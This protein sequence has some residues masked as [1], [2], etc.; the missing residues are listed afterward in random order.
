MSSLHLDPCPSGGR[1][2]KAIIRRASLCVASLVLGLFAAHARAQTTPAVQGTS[3][4]DPAVPVVITT[5]PAGS[6]FF[7]LNQD[8]S[9]LQHSTVDTSQNQSCPGPSI[10][11]TT[12]PAQRTIVADLYNAYVSGADAPGVSMAI[13]GITPEVSCH[14]TNPFDYTGGVSAQSLAA[15]DT[16]HGS[17]FL[18][19]AYGGTGI[20]TLMVLNNLNNATVSSG[21]TFT[22]ALQIALDQNGQ[23]TSLVPDV[24]SDFGLT[25]ITELKTGTSP[26]NLW[27]YD[28]QS[29]NV[30]KILGP[31][32]VSLPAVTSFIIPPQTGGGGL[33]VLVN[34][35][36]LTA[37]NIG[38]PPQETAP[39]TIIDLGQLRLLFATN[40][41]H[42][43]ITLPFVEQIQATTPFYAMLGAAYN[44]I[45]HRIYAVVGGGTS[46]TNVVE[47]IL[48]YD[49]LNPSAP[50]EK[51]VADV[52]NVPFSLGSYPQLALSAASG[53]MQILTSNPAAVYSVGIDGTGNTAVEVS[54]TTFPDSNF[55]PTYIAANALQGE[56]YIASASGQV[57]VL[58]RPASLQG[59]LTITLTGPD[60]SY[61]SQEYDLTPLA[62]W[63]LYDASLGTAKLT[64]TVT[65]DGGA[66]VTVATGH[67]SDIGYPGSSFYTYTFPAPGRYTFV[68]T[69]EASAL[70]PAVTSP[71][72]YVYVGNTGVYPTAV[73]LTAPSTAPSTNGEATF[74]ATV[75]LTG[76]TYAPTGQVYI[77]DQTG[78]EVANISLPAGVISNPLTL[79]VTIG[80]G[81]S[82]L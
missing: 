69:A 72:L 4:A 56:T 3:I 41:A 31:G 51:V 49:T 52:S 65:P 73:S 59:G 66:P 42:N 38:A 34:Q 43:T 19:S 25:A 62:L 20:D 67:I 32:G 27:V 79:P 68:A 48:S 10:Y 70:Y 24:R 22:G 12:D 8:Y 15:N 18:V 75:N 21:N 60:L 16:Q 2:M 14:M 77:Q 81:V 7:V 50:A 46:L 71:P 44:P 55:Q 45:D 26:G 6:G 35:H 5:A 30:F 17:Y 36:G 47:S 74:N 58:T 78:A 11:S 1:Y 40:P 80:D 9:V 39:F 82:T 29:K 13:T 61:T 53:T 64:I 33:L 57:D 37:T 23:Y 76:T 54:G 28:P 63:P